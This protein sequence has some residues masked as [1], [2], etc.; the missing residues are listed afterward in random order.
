MLRTLRYPLV[1]LLCLAALWSLPGFF[2]GEKSTPAA[3]NIRADYFAQQDALYEAIKALDSLAAH[4][5]TAAQLRE[6]LH[7]TR[8][9][10]KRVEALLAYLEGA[11]TNLY[12]NG[13]PLP[14]LDPQ[15]ENKITVL[16]PEGLQRLDEL[17][18]AEP[19]AEEREHIRR[20]TAD[21][22][23]TYGSIMRYQQRALYLSDRQVFE[24]MRQQVLRIYTLGVTGFDTP[25]SGLALPEAAAA[26]DHLRQMAAQYAA[27]LAER[28]RAGLA[29]SIAQAFEAGLAQLDR[30]PDFDAFDRIAFF[31]Q[32]IDPLYGLLLDAHL[33]LGFETLDEVHNFPHAVNYASRSLF[34]ADFLNTGFYANTESD[35]SLPARV[36]L[37]RL[38]FF[39]PVLS[40][41]VERSCASCHDPRRGFTDGRPKSL[42]T[43]GQGTLSRNSPTL[44]NAVYADR[45]FHDLRTAL[46]ESQVDHVITDDKEFQMTY[47]DILLRLQESGEYQALFRAAFPTRPAHRLFTQ[48]T[49]TA[50]LAAYVRT[51]TAFDTPVDRYLRG[52]R[53][54]L[55]PAVYRGYNLFM[56]KAACGT[57][58]FAPVF[59]G[60]V[61]PVYRESESE[62]LGV[63]ARPDTAGATVDAD[64]GRIANGRPLEEAE[65][66][67]HA[68]KTPTVRNIGLSGPYMHNGVYE[69]LA[70]VM[71]FYNRGGGAGIG[72]DLPNQ[73]LPPDPLALDAREIADLIAF[74]E[75]LS[76]TT[77]LTAVPGRLPAFPVG[78]PYSD[79]P[80]GGTY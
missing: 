73:T 51:L 56:G 49:L 4:E 37:G 35:P 28:Q 39:D 78:L 5:A 46:L 32:C 15:A 12:L 10:Y 63:P 66:Y 7:R 24:A 31:R 54:T 38:L 72:I 55:D 70:E 71:D 20:L 26:L 19:A 11:Y 68:F 64:L 53:D 74:M 65:I 52:E 13:A 18:Y 77:G 50:A 42:A 25:G 16:Q 21:L 80:I 67:R 47:A 62:V 6:A 61:P 58:H 29:D 69:T 45:Y 59:N 27:P 3:A 75:A 1:V 9:Q 79:R 33:A 40:R 41:T 30:Q 48:N 8:L 57:C 44:I 34:A 76:D 17:I 43:G 36:E 2:A 60:T 23:R 14:K 22:L